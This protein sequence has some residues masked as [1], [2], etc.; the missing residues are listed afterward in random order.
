[1]LSE[2][3]SEEYAGVL[4]TVAADALAEAGID[5]PPVDPFALAWAQGITVAADGLQPGRGRS[6]R[7][8]G[9]GGRPLRPAVLLRPE[10]RPERCHWALA[11][12]IGEHLAHR[13]FGRLN[14]VPAETLPGA[15]ESVANQLAGRLLVP[16]CW[17]LEDGTACGW[18][19]LRL[20]A[21]YGTAS[22]ELLAR[23]MLELPPQVIVT[24]V[25]QG[26]VSFRRSNIPGQVPPM[27]EV[28]KECQRQAHGS[29]CAA[30]GQ[31]LPLRV[32]AW[33][34]HEPLWRR[35]ILRT[36]VETW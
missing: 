19:L 33:P 7:L 29:G 11:H 26:T 32:R 34:V 20:K 22:H 3:T 5:K 9:R 16:S 21:R 2:V 28:E 17:F 15:R 31:C 1:M 6:V 36:E 35:E 12:E 18:D 4:D 27:A 8:G 14:V 10:S 25:D 24:V 30:S 23:R 13:V